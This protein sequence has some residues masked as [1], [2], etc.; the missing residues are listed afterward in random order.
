[1]KLGV[2]TGSFNPIHNGH[3]KVMDFLINNNYVDR[4][5]I[6]ATT[7]YWDKKID[8]SL[9]DRINM[10]KCINKDYL[11]VEDKL[12]N[13]EYTYM[14]LNALS[15][16]FKGDELYLIMAADN[17]VN[18]D[19]WKNYQ[20]ILNYKVIILNR[21]NIDIHNYIDKY[22]SSNFIVIQD[23]EY[24]DISSTKLRS[25]L[26]NNYLDNKVLKYIKDNKLYQ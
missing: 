8:V 1:M 22:N 26:D 24:I 16:K 7:S 23:F 10:I 4:I 5:I 17:I 19:K 2:F 12:N 18:F 21:D 14:L 20:E 6:V 3:I 13:I 11:I 15:K 25:N 9:N